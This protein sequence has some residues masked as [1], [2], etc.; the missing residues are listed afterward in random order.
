MRAMANPA[1]SSIRNVA[2]CGHGAAG[3]TT[4]V[5]K[6]LTITGTVNR[7]A[8]VDDGTSIC[9]F[10]EEE[11][12]HKY[13]IESK[14]VHF[15]HRG[16]FFHAIDTPG[17]PDYIGQ[18][19]GALYGVETAAI[20]INAQ[21]GLGVNT[22]RMF[23]E[24]GRL[25]LARMLIINR[26][27]LENVDFPALLASIQE[28]W[29][30]PCVLYNAPIGQGADFRGVVSCL[31]GGDAPGALVDVAKAHETLIEAIVE[32]DEAATE[33]YFDGIVPQGEELDRLLKQSI[34]SGSLIPIVCCAG[35][36]GVG[37][38]ELLDALVR[39]GLAPSDRPCRAL[40]NGQEVEVP[41]D[42]AGPLLARVF[43]T[44][45]DPFVQKL[46]FI[47]VYS[48]TL[49]RDDTVPCSTARKPV[50]ITQL[51]RVQANETQQIDSASAGQIVAVAKTE[52]FRTG[53][54]LGEFELPPM[55]FP[56]PMVGLA[57]S[58][59]SR[60]DEAKLSGALA[61][62]AEEE[63]TF[64]VDRDAQTK[65]L[66]IT[67]MS[68]L[69]LQ[70]IVERLKRRDKVE[71]VTAEPKIPYRETVQAKAE[72]SYRHK[73]QTGGRGQFGEVHIRMFPFPQGTDPAAFCTPERFPQM[74][75]FHHDPEINFLWVNSIVGGTIPSNFLPA[76]EKG[77]RER[78]SRGVIAGYQVVNVGVEVFFGKY[79]EVDSSEA[80]F[81]TA[82]SMCFRNVFQEAR[83]CLLE[84]IV[85][86]HVTVPSDKLGDI[87][88]DLSTRR[89]RV[90]GTDAAGGGYM[91]VS[92]EVPLAEVTTYARS[93]SS[94]TAGQ[95]SYTLEFSH[96]DVVPPHVQ[97]EIMEKAQLKEEEDD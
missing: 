4:L 57:A 26:M 65:E 2:F 43:K 19:I 20:V 41:A 22:R 93:L 82:G 49:K 60:G 1:V 56:T 51:Y 42:P 37:V 8:S 77:F 18:A 54:V 89:G 39:C 94:M 5:D 72:G 50:R 74:K 88:S 34:A 66:V 85:K 52:E 80:A 16:T 46:S 40:R 61:K 36:S 29:G 7:P 9:D 91:T 25:G 62:I 15:Q 12:Q 38:P 55:R 71:V 45:V 10:E 30:K 21:S 33:R 96:Y 31:E 11:K 75:E 79:H 32:V 73:K 63:P 35:K 24:A 23:D 6:L 83:P 17:Y 53:T 27:D 48:G 47:R 90:L 86:L 14:V 13:T 87:N 28:M 67:G 44:R 58:P 64:R 76:V 81:K 59:K 3:K 69:H 78:M 68:E 70:V 92:A 97:K 95:G 84:P